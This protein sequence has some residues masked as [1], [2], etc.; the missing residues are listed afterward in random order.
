M[1]MSGKTLNYIAEVLRL[2]AAL[3]AG[4]AGSSL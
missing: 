3:L 1:T 2:I 4:W